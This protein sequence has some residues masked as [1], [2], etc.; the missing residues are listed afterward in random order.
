MTFWKKINHKIGKSVK[1]TK[2][3]ISNVGKKL[4][5]AEKKIDKTINKGAKAVAKGGTKA[6]KVA[7]KGIEF[8]EEHAG[9]IKAV[10]DITAE[11]VSVVGVATGQPEI[12]AGAQALKVGAD[13][14]LILLKKAKQTR[15]AAEK[16]V[17]VAQAIAEKKKLSEVISLT[18]DAMAEAGKVS[19]N[20][21]LEM[22]GGHVKKGSVIVDKAVAHTE[23]IH[24]IVKEAGQVKDVGGALD[25][26]GKAID[27]GRKIQTTIGEAKA[28]KDD[29]VKTIKPETKA[30]TTSSKGKRPLSAYNIFMSKKMKEEGLS[31][32]ESVDAWNEQKRLKGI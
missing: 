27:E 24:G 21:E 6:L 19:G 8:A 22:M 5:S 31:F 15:D 32:R 20:K 30:K 18:G 25:V 2:K 3:D 28:L 4:A 17:L 13:R 7:D 1:H 9:T 26:L 10:V 12:V 11:V 16:A 14:A 29:I 23:A